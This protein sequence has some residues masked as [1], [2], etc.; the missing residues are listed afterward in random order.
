MVLNAVRIKFPENKKFIDNTMEDSCQ[1]K[2][3][4]VEE[5]ILHKPRS[6]E[7]AQKNSFCFAGNYIKL[8]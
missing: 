4:S 8:S 2:K 3:I 1:K 6:K 5:V 7:L